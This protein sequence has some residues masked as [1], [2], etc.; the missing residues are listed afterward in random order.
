MSIQILNEAVSH[1]TS[2]QRNALFAN[3]PP[4]WALA[5]TYFRNH[6]N[7]KFTSRDDVSLLISLLRTVA[8]AKLKTSTTSVRTQKHTNVEDISF[9]WERS[10]E[11]ATHGKDSFFMQPFNVKTWNRQP[12]TRF[13]PPSCCRKTISGWP[14]WKND[15]S[16]TTLMELATLLPRG[17]APNTL[18]LFHGTVARFK[19]NLLR[20]IQW[21]LGSGTLGPGFYLT[22]NPNVSKAYACRA[23]N[24]NGLR[25]NEKLVVLEIHVKNTDKISRVFY[26]DTSFLKPAASKA[27]FVYNTFPGFDGQ[28]CLRGKSIQ[29]CTI[30][31]VH[32][33]ESNALITIDTTDSHKVPCLFKD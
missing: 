31:I 3:D 14:R 18:C 9:V 8:N 24:V 19:D 22:H 12:F 28:V 26:D 32:V 21:T 23:A 1:L 6:E 30:K 2:M 7:E 10:V 29:H 11:H 27:T 20:Q 25:K 33:L 13:E 5:R 16:A 4:T 15:S 17:L